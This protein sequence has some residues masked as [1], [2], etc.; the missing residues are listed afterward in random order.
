[1]TDRRIGQIGHLTTMGLCIADGRVA[2]LL[3]SPDPTETVTELLIYDGR[4]SSGITASTALAT[5]TMLSGQEATTQ[6][7]PPYKTAYRGCAA[8]E[9]STGHWRLPV[10]TIRCI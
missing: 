9:R 5:L 7:S 8:T 4:G 1:M 10:K 6:S 2:R 3:K